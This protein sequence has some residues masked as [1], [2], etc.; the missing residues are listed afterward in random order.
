MNARY[1]QRS[2][3]P[4]LLLEMEVTKMSIQNS[5]SLRVRFFVRSA[6]SG[7]GP[8]SRVMQV[9]VKQ[10]LLLSVV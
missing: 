2:M 5:W 9:N 10:R 8:P 7:R 6:G 1:N 4:L 3:Y